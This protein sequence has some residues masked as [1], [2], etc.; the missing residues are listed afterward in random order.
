MAQAIEKPARTARLPS[1]SV[2]TDLLQA[3]ETAE[4][5]SATARGTYGE[6]VKAAEAEHN[7]HTR[8]WGHI[9]SLVKMGGK[10]PVKLGEYLHHFDAM[11][12][13]LKLDNMKA[14]DMLPDRAGKADGKQATGG[15]K[16]KKP[17]KAK[18]D[19]GGKPRAGKPKSNVAPLKPPASVEPTHTGVETAQ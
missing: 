12:E 11:R 7:L 4:H 3:K 5:K 14:A 16:P 15:S 2:L 18:K 8:A 17:A 10:D 9:A 19:N 6:K 1:K 13:T